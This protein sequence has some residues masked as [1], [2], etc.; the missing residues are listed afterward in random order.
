MQAK[1]KEDLRGICAF[2]AS[3]E[4][5]MLPVYSNVIDYRN[6]RGEW[7]PSLE[8][9]AIYETISTKRCLQRSRWAK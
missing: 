1:T 7:M 8:R 3:Q 4:A 5:L 6:E 2:Y 9:E